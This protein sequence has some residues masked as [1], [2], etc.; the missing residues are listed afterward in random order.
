[1]SKLTFID[2]KKFAGLMSDLFP[3]IKVEDIKY[4]LVTKAVKESLKEKGLEEVPAQM[5]K[6]LQFYEHSKQ[7]MGVV[8]VG[9]S[10]CGKT[11]IW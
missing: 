10:G 11:T 3:G 6:I 1:M 9:P 7:R 8:L 5:A 2:S 4:D